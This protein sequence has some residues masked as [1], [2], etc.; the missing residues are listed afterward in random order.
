MKWNERQYFFS[1]SACANRTLSVCALSGPSSSP[2]VRDWSERDNKIDDLS[3]G[4]QCLS[5]SLCM[6]ERCGAMHYVYEID[7]NGYAFTL[8]F[9]F[10][11]FILFVSSFALSSYFLFIRNSHFRFGVIWFFLCLSSPLFPSLHVFVCISLTKLQQV[12][13]DS[14]WL[15]C[16]TEYSRTQKIRNGSEVKWVI[17]FCPRHCSCQM[18]H[19]E[20]VNIHI[21][22][23][24]PERQ[25]L[26]FCQFFRICV[27]CEGDT[28]LP[29]KVSRRNGLNWF[30]Y[31]SGR[32][33]TH[34]IS[35]NLMHKCKRWMTGYMCALASPLHA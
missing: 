11:Y 13:N 22:F 8:C 7:M 31:F 14:D 30:A 27:S 33:S 23:R 29:N 20:I 3:C 18:R 12:A 21:S 10:I 25:T 28:A 15:R 4:T 17:F 2:W 1:S 35:F 32:W 6:R 19:R 16:G 5:Q 26:C 34:S 24:S 9:A